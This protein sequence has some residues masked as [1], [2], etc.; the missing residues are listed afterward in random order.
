MDGFKIELIKKVK[1]K[2]N[3]FLDKF[4]EIIDKYSNWNKLL[5]FYGTKDYNLLI[6]LV[7]IALLVLAFMIFISLITNINE[8]KILASDVCKLC[9]DKTG[10]DC[11]CFNPE[12]F[13][14][15]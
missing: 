13:H 11:F 12:Y 2:I 6:D 4:I 5:E 14:V 7:R 15:K 3:H 1:N 10:C 9:I 8:V